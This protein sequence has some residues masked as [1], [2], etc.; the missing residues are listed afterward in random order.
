MEIGLYI[1]ELLSEQDEVSVTGLG[2]FTKERIAGK[3]DS[4]SNLFYPP[5]IKLLNKM[6]SCYLC[7]SLEGN[8]LESA[9][10][11]IL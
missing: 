10:R 1:A 8:H 11:N 5:P 7:D 4:Q 9:R 3:L 2:T 6:Y